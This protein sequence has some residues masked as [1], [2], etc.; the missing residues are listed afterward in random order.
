[1]FVGK[2]VSVALKMFGIFFCRSGTGSPKVR[3]FGRQASYNVKT[4]LKKIPNVRILLYCR[5]A[6]TGSSTA[7]CSVLLYCSIPYS[8]IILASL[9]AVA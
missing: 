2:K 1:M 9:S 6:T 3:R 7:L 4:V 5:P 8:V